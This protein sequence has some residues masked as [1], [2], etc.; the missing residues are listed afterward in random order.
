MTNTDTLAETICEQ[1]F[2]LTVYECLSAVEKSRDLLMQH[3][4][5]AEH[6]ALANRLSNMLDGLKLK[7]GEVRLQQRWIDQAAEMLASGQPFLVDFPKST[8]GGRHD[9]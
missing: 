3:V 7:I 8:A 4:F 9:G 5:A 2:H 1:V 6:P